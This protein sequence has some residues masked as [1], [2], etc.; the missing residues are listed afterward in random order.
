[1]NEPNYSLKNEGVPE[2]RKSMDQEKGNGLISVVVGRE[3]ID[4]VVSLASRQ[5]GRL[6]VE[7]IEVERVERHC[8]RWDMTGRNGLLTGAE[9]T[10]AT[11]D[12]KAEAVE[13]M[14]NTRL[15]IKMGADLRRL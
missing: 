4:V 1:M 11:V 3:L 2:V 14:I 15:K 6:V 13:S 10:T 8:R 5:P 9:T 12:K 7:G